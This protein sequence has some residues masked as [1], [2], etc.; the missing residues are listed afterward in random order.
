MAHDRVDASHWSIVM[1][2]NERDKA[3]PIDPGNQMEN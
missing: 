3:L 1:K 2:E